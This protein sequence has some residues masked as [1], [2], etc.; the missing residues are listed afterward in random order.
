M[1]IRCGD[2]GR[3]GGVLIEFLLVVI[4]LLVI[5][6]GGIEYGRAMY[7]RNFA[8]EG[9]RSAAREAATKPGPLV[10]PAGPGPL[11]NDPGVFLENFTA[12]DLAN[13]RFPSGAPLTDQDGDADVDIDDQF[14]V[15]PAVHA[16]LRGNMFTDDVTLPP[17]RL[18]RFHGVLLRNAA[19]AFDVVVRVPDVAGAS[20]P[21]RRIVNPPAAV[22]AQGMVR[23]ECWQWFKF[24]AYPFGGAGLPPLAYS[25]LPPGFAVVTIDLDPDSRQGTVLRSYAVARKEIQ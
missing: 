15:L 3:E 6:F 22:D 4:L 18:L 11:Y 17:R 1:K 24:T 13:L 10:L 2:G 21:L 8:G 14:A 5:I 19:A 20:A 12:I 25:N 23:M 16:A 9:A 7:A